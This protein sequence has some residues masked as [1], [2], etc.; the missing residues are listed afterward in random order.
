MAGSAVAEVNVAA[1]AVFGAVYA[2]D[3]LSWMCYSRVPL[4]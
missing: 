1:N 3:G 4:L 2:D